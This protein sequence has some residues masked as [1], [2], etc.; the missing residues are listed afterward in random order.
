MEYLLLRLCIF[1][2]VLLLEVILTLDRA[3]FDASK[4]VEDLSKPGTII[5]M[6]LSTLIISEIL[7]VVRLWLR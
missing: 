5:S 7:Y 3:H 4:F 1:L 6:L 2:P